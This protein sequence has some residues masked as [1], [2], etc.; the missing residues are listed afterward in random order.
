MNS[1]MVSTRGS[2]NARAIPVVILGIGIVF[3]ISVFLFNSGPSASLFPTPRQLVFALIPIAILSVAIWKPSWAS[4]CFIALIFWLPGPVDHL[5]DVQF[6]F[7][8]SVDK[9]RTISLLDLFFLLATAI[10]LTRHPIKYRKLTWWLI[11]G[12]LLALAL[13]ILIGSLWFFSI[14]PAI[15]L[16][17]L[18][19]SI[20]GLR[21]LLVYLWVSRSFETIS[22]LRRFYVGVAIGLMGLLANTL[23]VSLLGGNE[24]GRI[25]AG[26]F[27]NNSFSVL[28]AVMCVLVV[29]FFFAL[30]HLTWRIGLFFVGT[31]ALAAMIL[32]GTRMALVVFTMGIALTYLCSQNRFNG[33]KVVRTVL[34]ALILLVLSLVGMRLFLNADVSNPSLARFQSSISALLGQGSSSTNAY[35]L[36][37]TLS[38]R[39]VIWDAALN[40]VEQSPWFG[41]GAGQWNFERMFTGIF[42]VVM[43]SGNPYTLT[44]PHNG[45]I[46]IVTEFGYPA[47]AIYVIIVVLGL[48]SGARNVLLTRKQEHAGVMES[49][50][51][52][53]VSGLFAAMSMFVLAEMTNS[54]IM[55]IHFQY[56][57]G[58]IIFSQF[59]IGALLRQMPTRILTPGLS[60]SPIIKSAVRTSDIKDAMPPL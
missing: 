39:G 13:H 32:T 50:Y 3:L 54:Y 27:G 28:L 41:I 33:K 6:S 12:L 52:F 57:Y 31:A 30:R 58:I 11:L 23:F 34:Y 7:Y 42:H 22:S 24:S 26:T 20:M 1:S 8:A 46:H 37:S 15:R 60:K 44:D 47:V 2:S 48:V 38:A 25:A 36:F 17:A 59:R 53:L 4:S 18:L 5:F 40:M 43:P 29:Q 21:L 35:V 56:F 9:A 51:K 55:K 14:L 45:Y 49:Q 19:T 16:P 10:M